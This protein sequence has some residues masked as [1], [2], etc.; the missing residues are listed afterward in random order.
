[1]DE[2]LQL[3]APLMKGFSSISF[4]RVKLDGALKYR[5]NSLLYLKFNSVYSVNTSK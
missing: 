2:E 5:I 1:M 3:L 4:T